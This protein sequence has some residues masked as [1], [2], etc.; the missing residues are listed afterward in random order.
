MKPTDVE[1]ETPFHYYLKQKN[2]TNCKFTL[3]FASM[4]GAMDV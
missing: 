1:A 4:E 2:E 3:S